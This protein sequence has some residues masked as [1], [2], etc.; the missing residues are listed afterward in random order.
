MEKEKELEDY[1]ISLVLL[2]FIYYF[3]KGYYLRGLITMLISVILPKGFYFV[4]GLFLGFFINNVE[5]KKSKLSCKS[6]FIACVSVVVFCGLK[7]LRFMLVHS[8]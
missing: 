7:Y 8:L 4:V 5:V 1:S 3:A 2:N 6:C